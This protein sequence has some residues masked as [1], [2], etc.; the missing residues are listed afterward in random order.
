MEVKL[1]LIFLFLGLLSIFWAENK[2]LVLFREAQIILAVG[3]FLAG[4]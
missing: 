2:N 4:C 3:F 1:L